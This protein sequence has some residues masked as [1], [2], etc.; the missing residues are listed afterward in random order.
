MVFDWEY[1]HGEIFTEGH[2]RRQ[3]AKAVLSLGSP[4]PQAGSSLFLPVGPLSFF[5]LL[6][7]NFWLC[8][9]AHTYTPSIWEV[10]AGIQDS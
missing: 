10:E 5:L 1:T 4:P 7:A 8:L 6:K 9:V 2:S 3:T